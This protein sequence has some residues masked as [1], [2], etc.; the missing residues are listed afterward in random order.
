MATKNR[1]FNKLGLSIKLKGTL[2]GYNVKR[3]GT[4]KFKEKSEIGPIELSYRDVNYHYNTA[5]HIFKHANDEQHLSIIVYENHPNWSDIINEYKSEYNNVEIDNIDLNINIKK[6]EPVLKV[7]EETTFEG[8]SI[9]FSEEDMLK[10]LKNGSVIE[11]YED[12]VYDI[13]V[14]KLKQN[15]L[16]DDLK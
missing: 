4:I 5:Y 2:V 16:P 6:P 3:R 14:K 15:T 9:E 13:I 1:T 8:T 7:L 12:I 11:G 10:S